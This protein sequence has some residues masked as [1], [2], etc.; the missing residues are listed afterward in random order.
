MCSI[1]C[2]YFFNFLQVACKGHLYVPTCVSQR[3]Y[4]GGHPYCDR[5]V[6]PPPPLPNP[7]T[8]RLVTV[9]LKSHRF[10]RPGRRGRR[11]Q[12]APPTT[13]GDNRQLKMLAIF[14]IAQVRRLFLIFPVAFFCFGLP[15]TASSP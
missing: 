8:A 2:S 9:G 13:S 10:K 11:Q 3:V 12:S 7:M 15:F 5:A 4:G 14:L 6:T 1:Y